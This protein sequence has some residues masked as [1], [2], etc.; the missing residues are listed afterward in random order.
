[1]IEMQ[2]LKLYYKQEQQMVTR[3]ELC[4]NEN[5]SDVH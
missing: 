3:M 1:M 5:S 2:I 4:Q